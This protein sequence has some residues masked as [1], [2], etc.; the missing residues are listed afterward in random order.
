MA[1]GGSIDALYDLVVSINPMIGLFLE[2][3]R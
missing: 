3:R 2:L 1:T